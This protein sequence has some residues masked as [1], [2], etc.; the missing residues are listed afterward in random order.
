MQEF[1]KDLSDLNHGNICSNKW[2][3]VS[4]TVYFTVGLALWSPDLAY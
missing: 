4:F 1:T 2:R 3:Q